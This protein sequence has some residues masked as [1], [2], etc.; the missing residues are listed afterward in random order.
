MGANVYRTLKWVSGIMLTFLKLIAAHFI[1]D[2]L[3]Q[4]STMAT[5]KTSPK[6]LWGHG[7]IHTALYLAAL[8]PRPGVEALSLAFSVAVLHVL[9]DYV[10]ARTRRDGPVALCVDQGTHL[11]V[12]AIAASVAP[13][14][15]LPVLY[16]LRAVW[17]SPL[18]FF[19]VG[20]YVSIVIGAGHLVQRICTHFG[21]TL[22]QETLKR[23]PGLPAAGRYIGWLER[24]LI[25]TFLLAGHGEV[26][27]VLVGAKALVRYPDFKE[28]EQSSFADYFL[29]G[30]MTSV[31]L[32]LVGGIVL[33]RLGLRLRS[34]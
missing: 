9:I 12:V 7:A 13:T 14:D 10:K 17:M 21:A 2:F 31:G 1:G 11:T 28:G 25:V 20:G 22:D 4:P 33:Q 8:V 24:F 6:W 34:H 30:T 23:K 19:Y 5:R 26:I 29:V 18:L 16:S 32:G 3:L 27:A 15:S